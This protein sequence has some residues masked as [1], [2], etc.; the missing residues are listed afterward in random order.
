MLKV[1][2]GKARGAVAGLALALASLALGGCGSSDDDT[3]YTEQPVQLLYN[4][5]LDALG[6]QEYKAAAKAF[7]EVERQHP[8]S[9]WA[10]R[11]EIM[12]AYAYYQSNKYDEAI[13]ALDRFIELHPGHRDVPYAYYLKALCYYEQI[14]DVGR[15][16]RMTEQALDALTDV[17][18]RFPDIAYARDAR[19]KI[20]LAHRPSRRQGDGDRPL[21]PGEPAAISARSTASASWSS[22]TRPPPTC[23]RRCTA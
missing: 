21:L 8:Y 9:V 12:A 6:E 13:I 11:A 2:S 15:D 23:P 19:L 10:T 22:T 20:D 4:R 14:S 3:N 1:V 5:A 7:E 18:K 16:Q 17:V